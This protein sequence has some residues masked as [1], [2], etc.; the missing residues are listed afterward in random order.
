MPMFTGQTV[1]TTREARGSDT[2]QQHWLGG[3]AE[4]LDGRIFRY[5]QNAGTA[6]VRGNLLQAP[7][8][9]ANHLNRVVGDAAAVNDMFIT[10][11]IGATAT[12]ENQ[13]AD[14]YLVIN[15]AAGEG[16]AYRISGHPAQAASAT[17]AR[18]DISEPVDVALTADTSEGSLLSVWR[19]LI[20]HPTT[21]SGMAVGVADDAYAADVYF[22]TPVIGVTSVLSDANV[23]T[24]GQ[25][26][27]PSTTTAGCIAVDPT[28]AASP[29]IG[30]SPQASVSTEHRAVFMT[31]G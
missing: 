23:T 14:G 6:L 3:R 20:Q 27:V 24:V 25:V 16:I 21:F 18:Y 10:L 17:S 5:V 1:L 30:R 22:W 2:T 12:T 13:Y 15:D 19:D 4:T 11:D 29:Q 9:V 31:L 8:V 26:V 7:A 28:S